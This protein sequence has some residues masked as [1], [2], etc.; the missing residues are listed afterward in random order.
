MKDDG[1]FIAR[2]IN[3]RVGGASTLLR[4]IITMSYCHQT[5]SQCGPKYQVSIQKPSDD[6]DNIGNSDNSD[7][8]DDS[9]NSDD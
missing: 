4:D 1:N 5:Q 9:D 6:S 2:E 7:D 8:S 3:L